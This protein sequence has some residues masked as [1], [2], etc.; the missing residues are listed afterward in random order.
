MDTTSAPRAQTV[1]PL[2]IAQTGTKRRTRS[3][4][5][6]IALSILLL[7][8]AAVNVWATWLRPPFM[9]LRAI[10]GLI[11]VRKYNE[12]DAAL[13]RYLRDSPHDG[14][15]RM[16]LAR[17]K[18]ARN[19]L[20]G[21]A[22]ELMEVPA[23]WPSRFQAMFR[24]GQAFRQ[25][26]RA[27]DAETAWLACLETDSPLHPLPGDYYSD[28]ALELLKLYITQD[29]V[30]DAIKVIWQA[31]D[32]AELAEKSTVLGMRMRLELERIAPKA[33][34]QD[35]RKFV[36]ADPSDIE[37]RRALAKAE[38]ALGQS[39]LAVNLMMECLTDNPQSPRVW[40]DWLTL[41]H[42]RGELERLAAELEKAPPKVQELPVYWNLQGLLHER[43]SRLD[44]AAIAYRKAVE[45]VPNNAEFLYRLSIVETRLGKT[46]EAQALRARFK[47]INDARDQ[48]E[49]AYNSFS[50]AVLDGKTRT[51]EASEALR[52]IAEACRGMGWPRE[53][54][55]W[56]QV[57]MIEAPPEPRG[58]A[59]GSP[60]SASP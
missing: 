36:A 5:P 16:A 45:L 25:V 9:E 21:C 8:W 28:A 52:A 40:G 54:E 44:E 20:L 10:E 27:R 11:R 12:A 51:P 37:S 49:E 34:A 32:H 58:K 43:A 19:D 39:E 15:A 26:N 48:L 24:A 23:W 6:W 50:D 47:A 59:G 31:Y 17:V 4:A 53:A 35:L 30:E 33:T 1:A 56:T 55:A 13:A 2:V 18:A 22:R 57:R 7:G 14:D 3:K 60:A 41:L 38:Q 46:A 29:R 42:E